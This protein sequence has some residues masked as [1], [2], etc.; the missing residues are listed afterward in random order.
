MEQPAITIMNGQRIMAISTVRPDGWPQTTIVGYANAGFD[1]FFLIF[2]SSQKFANI[3][4]EPRVSVAIN[5]EA[6]QLE[7]LKAVFAGALATEVTNPREAE[8]AWKLLAGRHPNLG[9]YYR[10][11]AA[12]AVM[13]RAT[14]KHIS[15][16]DYSKGLGHTETLHLDAA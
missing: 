8:Q 16:F 13:I 15:V 9:S 7:D 4:H 10:P 2:R 14:C 1:I 11:D 3:Q 6:R 12:D 5:A